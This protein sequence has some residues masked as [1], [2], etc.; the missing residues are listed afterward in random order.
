MV[1]ASVFVKKATTWNSQT[2]TNFVHALLDR[3]AGN[4]S[5]FLQVWAV[6]SGIGN[7]LYIPNESDISNLD[8]LIKIYYPEARVVNAGM[9]PPSK[10]PVYAQTAFLHRPDGFDPKTPAYSLASTLKELSDPLIM[11]TNAM[12]NLQKDEHIA[13]QLHI[14]E[15]ARLNYGGYLLRLLK[16]AIER[17]ASPYYKS[18]QQK[19]QS[20]IDERMKN[21]VATA[22]IAIQMFTPNPRRFSVLSDMLSTISLFSPVG[23]FDHYY[24][25]ESGAIT[26]RDAFYTNHITPAVLAPAQWE[27]S[28]FLLTA[29][30]LSAYFLG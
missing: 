24:L 11:L 1:I 9:A 12:N 23:A 21:K 10:Y 22:R 5:L 8:H 25:E 17:R 15:Y 13:Y 18:E 19:R 16:D 26:N 14:G 28:A 4:K 3:Y 27:Q 20:E 2:A 6:N 30:E 29:D 7:G